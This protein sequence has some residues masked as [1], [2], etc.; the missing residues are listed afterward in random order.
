MSVRFGMAGGSLAVAPSPQL[1]RTPENQ[2]PAGVVLRRVNTTHTQGVL[3]TSSVI[4]NYPDGSGA[5]SH[6]AP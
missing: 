5:R 4:D 6:L 2:L 3:A 1:P